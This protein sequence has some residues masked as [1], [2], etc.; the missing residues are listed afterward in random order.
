MIKKFDDFD[1]N[2]AAT[3]QLTYLRDDDGGRM[4]YKGSDGNMYVEVEGVIHDMTDEGE[5]ISPVHNVKIK[6]GEPVYDPND[7][8]GK[9]RKK[10]N[11][12]A[13]FDALEK[14]Q[15]IKQFAFEQADAIT[16]VVSKKFKDTKERVAVMNVLAR[17]I[18]GQE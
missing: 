13:D 8:F 4:L 18:A 6:P 10:T 16:E 14:R 5:P 1:I 9:N 12:N 3:V 17:L 15:D 2:E 7:R 11:E